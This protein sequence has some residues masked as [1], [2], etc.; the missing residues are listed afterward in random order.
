LQ[1]V[2]K[3][4]NDKSL[5]S[6][7]NTH[8]YQGENNADS[9]LFLLPMVYDDINLLECQVTL[10][11]LNNDN[12]GNA[13]ILYPEE[14]LYKDVYLQVTLPLTLLYTGVI[15]KLDLW[16]NITNSEYGLVL[17]T[18]NVN[19]SISEHREL[20][21]VVLPENTFTILD[22]YILQIQE[23]EGR[24]DNYINEGII[25]N[26]EIGTTTTLSI[27][28]NATVYLDESSTET[29]KIFNFGIPMG[30][31]D[32]VEETTIIY[33]SKN[34]SDSNLGNTIIKPKLTIS[35]AL[36][37]ALSLSSSLNN[38][39][40]IQVVGGGIYT[41]S[42]SLG[43][44]LSLDMPNAT[45]VGSIILANYT[46]VIIDKHYSSANNQ[47][48]VTKTGQQHSYYTARLSDGRGISGTLTGVTNI[49]N[50]TNNSITF[51]K[52]DMMFSSINGILLRDTA[53]ERG[54]L[55]L[56]SLDCYLSQGG[57]AVYA[58]G[59][60]SDLIGYIDHIIKIGEA[61]GT[62]AIRMDG[63]NSVVKV[64]INEINTDNAYLINGGSL[65]L[66]CFCVNGNK[67]GTPMFDLSNLT[68]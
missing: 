46:S 34:G 22:Q 26:I 2:I 23:L 28:Q 55:H 15:G 68:T 58:Q 39:V 56:H 14:E 59:N 35:S 60:E 41:E 43:S 25:P 30:S 57:I 50:T 66:N 9:I 54:H 6:S 32:V 63:A 36:T 44:Y 10:E 61:T 17:K 65:Y 19:I 62:T 3:M 13:V 38:R 64:T 37:R 49:Y 67:N 21:G 12:D 27:G 24:I 29:N 31:V 47:N 48:M 45:L 1:L 11:W 52:V 33:V 7:I 5:S 42:F 18:S 8:I 53:S 20:D 51:G 40:I 4:N 16:L